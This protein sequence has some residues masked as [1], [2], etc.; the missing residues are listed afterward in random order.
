MLNNIPE[1]D[2]PAD[3]MF[4]RFQ[5]PERL[6]IYDVSRA[7]DEVQLT[8]AT[9]VGLINRPR[10]R[11]YMRYHHD[12]EVWLQHI[13]ASIVQQRAEATHD[14]VLG[15]LLQSY[16]TCVQGM[17]IYDPNVPDS[18][19]VATTMAGQEDGMVVSPEQAEA[20]R[21]P[22]N[23]PV[24]ADLRVHRWPD[25]T[26]AYAWARK[27]LLAGASSRL[28][29]GL[30]PRIAAGLRAFLVATRAFVYWLDSRNFLPD[31]KYWL[32]S[33][34]CLM[35]RILASFAPGTIH[36]GWFIHEFSGVSLASEAALPVLASD[37][38][39]NLEVWTS[40]QPA[41]YED[42]ALTSANRGDETT[43]FAN[44]GDEITGVGADL[45]RPGVGRGDLMDTGHAFS[46]APPQGAINRP[47]R[48]SSFPIDSQMYLS[49]TMS[50]GD[51]LQYMQ[52]K[53][54]HLWLDPA[55]ERIPLGWTVAP[56]IAQ[57]APVI[58]AYYTRSATDN[59]ELIAGPS[60]AGYMYPSR[61]PHERLPAF[62]E[63]SG[64]LMQSMNL[65]LLEALDGGIA[66]IMGV[67]RGRLQAFSSPSLQ[68]TYVQALKPYGLRGILS[69]SGGK[70]PS[71]SV[72]DGVPIYQNLGLAQSIEDIKQLV[73]RAAASTKQP[74]L[75]LNIYVE[76]WR[77][78]PTQ[79]EQVIKSL[80][81]GY[82]VVT[83]GELLALIARATEVSG[84]L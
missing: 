81:S 69:G 66:Q 38:F 1:I 54:L 7:S 51:N 43:E 40:I 42:G 47:L 16:R 22:Y 46:S 18:I 15:A 8:L 73:K 77:V 79:I 52:H 64:K 30:D 26:A 32:P 25:R 4:P 24:L 21:L 2:W 67:A 82:T 29:A 63:Q 74:P 33:Q 62:L 68:R 56:A 70:R 11:V 75:F 45:S 36:L 59:S 48:T 27:N 84:K 3:R 72:V 65:S 13:P 17:I 71:W 58:A 80:G 44:R 6:V 28:V 14:A 60:G 35:R 55:R 23:L 39:T 20:L 31:L 10:P 5:T 78:T 50:D 76:A 41:N 53:M 49:F 9:L 12:D 57:A 19:N 37:H 83:P 61:W 34:R